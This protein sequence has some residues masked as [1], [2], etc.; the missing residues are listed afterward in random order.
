M[1]PVDPD[2][3]RLAEVGLVPIR[4]NPSAFGIS[5]SRRVLGGSVKALWIPTRRIGQE[6]V[7]Q[8]ELSPSGIWDG[9]VGSLHKFNALH[10]EDP[11]FPTWKMVDGTDIPHESGVYR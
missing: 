3:A 11:V 4:S 10:N 7:S 6:F 9:Y 2:P 5:A 8:T 1:G